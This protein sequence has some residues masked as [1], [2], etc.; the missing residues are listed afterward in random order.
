[1][2]WDEAF[3]SRYDEWSAHMTA[4][5]AFYVSLALQADGPLVELA[6]GNGRVAIP[7]AQATG[8][9]CWVNRGFHAPHT[10]SESEI[11]RAD[12]SVDIAEWHRSGF[13][14]MS[15]PHSHI[16]RRVRSCSEVGWPDVI[17]ECAIKLGTF[18]N[19]EIISERRKPCQR[20]YLNL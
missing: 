8:A 19:V 20:K 11:D 9:D 7:I 13:P 4:D 15:S 18:R 2:S 14:A 1:M 12:Q 5:I 10:E 17:M 3:A 16:R 6:I